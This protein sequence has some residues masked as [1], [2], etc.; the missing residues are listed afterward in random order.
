MK[1]STA[2]FTIKLSKDAKAFLE[3]IEDLKVKVKRMSKVDKL[4][5]AIHLLLV[6][7]GAA[8]KYKSLKNSISDSLAFFLRSRAKDG[9]PLFFLRLPGPYVKIEDGGKMS[10]SV[11]PDKVIEAKVINYPTEKRK[12]YNVLF[13]RSGNGDMLVMVKYFDYDLTKD[14]IEN[15]VPP[16]SRNLETVH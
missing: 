11:S 5:V 14:G 9:E 15:Y 2:L 16:L 7:T 12:P 13:G 3:E 4:D 10:I 8:E 1:K 6:S